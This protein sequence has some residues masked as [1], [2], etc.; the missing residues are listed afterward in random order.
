MKKQNLEQQP[1]AQCT[2]NVNQMHNIP[3]DIYDDI[4]NLKLNLEKEVMLRKQ[5]EEKYSIELGKK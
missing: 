1:H 3:K 4:L 2:S 5:L